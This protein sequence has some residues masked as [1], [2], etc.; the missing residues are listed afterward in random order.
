VEGPPIRGDLLADAKDRRSGFAPP[1]RPEGASA[2][3]AEA[4]GG[5]GQEP[6]E[7]CATFG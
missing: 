1:S 6:F 4:F 2:S 7:D 3:L 5:G